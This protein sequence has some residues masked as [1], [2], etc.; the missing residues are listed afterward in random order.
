MRKEEIVMSRDREMAKTTGKI[1]K[2]VNTSL[3][4]KNE[5][6]FF[7]SIVEL[8]QYAKRNLEKQ[9]NTT[10]VVTY[11]VYSKPKNRQPAVSESGSRIGE[12]VVTQFNM[13]TRISETLFPQFNSNITW[14]HYILLT[15][16]NNPDERR[17]Y[18]IEIEIGTG[19][20]T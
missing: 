17:F 12:P 11:V 13:R 2:P 18:E 3:Y 14:S 19:D 20:Y 5:S 1:F 8:I 4:E 10:M 7:Q 15:R 9:V 16:I 6:D